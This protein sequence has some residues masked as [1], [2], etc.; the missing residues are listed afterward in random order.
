MTYTDPDKQRDFMAAYLSSENA[1]RPV[2]FKK[3]LSDQHIKAIRVQSSIDETT[4]SHVIARYVK[5]GLS[6]DGR[7]K[8][9]AQ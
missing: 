3:D 9:S 1:W 6:R 7:I 2:V 8:A 4:I 5:E